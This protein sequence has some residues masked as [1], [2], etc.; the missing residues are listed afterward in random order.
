VGTGYGDTRNDIFP[1]HRQVEM[2]SI[3]VGLAIL[4]I[5]SVAWSCVHINITGGDVDDSNTITGIEIE[6]EQD[7]N[8]ED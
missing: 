1:L 5:A 2:K 7:A 4:I 3:V 6:E 8:N